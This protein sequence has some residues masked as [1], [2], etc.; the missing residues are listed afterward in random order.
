MDLED[1]RLQG[2]RFRN[3]APKRRYHRNGTPFLKG[4]VPLDW[5]QRAMKLG[6]GPLS[7]GIVLW[8]LRGL[9]KSESFKV[10]IGDIGG[11]VSC[12][13]RTTHRSLRS[14]EQQGLVTM[15]RRPGRK[16]LITITEGQAAIW[17]GEFH[18]RPDDS[19]PKSGG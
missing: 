13:W 7:V 9:K 3:V 5:L 2:P 14:L 10:G 18:G 8:Y 4:P 16:H 12:S 1:F 19:R 15:E 17:Q 6:L 11:L